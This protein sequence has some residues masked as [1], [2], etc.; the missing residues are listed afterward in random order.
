MTTTDYN[1]RSYVYVFKSNEGYETGR[2]C[3]VVK[4]GMKNTQTTNMYEVEQYLM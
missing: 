4:V 1:R 3:S 2:H